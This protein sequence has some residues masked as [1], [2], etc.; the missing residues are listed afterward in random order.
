MRTT[1]EYPVREKE[2]NEIFYHIDRATHL[3][4]GEK[5]KKEDYQD[6]RVAIDKLREVAVYMNEDRECG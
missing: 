4:W 5:L 3:C 2:L 6:L 1:E